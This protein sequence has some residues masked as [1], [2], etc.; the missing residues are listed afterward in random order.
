M[1]PKKTD[2]EAQKK[3]YEVY[4]ESDEWRKLEETHRE[5]KSLNYISETSKDSDLDGKYQTL[6]DLFY[7]LAVIMKI[8]P[9]FKK[10]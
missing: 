8:K 5:I 4:R 7:E 10:I 2:P 9:P 3:Q 1:P 6:W